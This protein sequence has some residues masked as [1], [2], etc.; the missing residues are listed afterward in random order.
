MKFLRF[1]LPFAFLIYLYRETDYL[2]NLLFREN[3]D[4]LFSGLEFKVFA[5]QPALLFASRWHSDIIA[6]L[7]YFGYFSYYFMA[8]GVP[9]IIFYKKDMLLGS[10]V[11]FVIICSFMIYYI[12]FIIFPVG[13]PKFFFAQSDSPLPKGYIFGPIMRIIE[14]YGEGATAAFPSSHVGVCLLLIW[15]AFRYYRKVLY[16]LIPVSVLLIL[17]TIYLRAHYII[18]LIAA[19]VVT[20]LMLFSTKRI[21][22]FLNQIFAGEQILLLNNYEARDY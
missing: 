11:A 22:R 18:D 1:M 3:L 20:P 8:F 5:T 17:S 15:F 19:V 2:N 10:K 9:L 16:F 14:R 12:I 4:P 21:Y 6:E 7:M 13:G